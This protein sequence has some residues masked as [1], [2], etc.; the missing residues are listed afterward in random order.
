MSK[1]NDFLRGVKVIDVSQFLPGPFA[2]LLMADMGATVLK[3]EPPGGDEAK[4]Y[5]PAFPDGTPAFHEATN[6]GKFVIEIDL[7]SATGKERFL[8]LAADADVLVE[9]FRPGVMEKLGLGYA[10]IKKRNPEI[11]YCSISGF[12]QGQ[13]MRAGHDGN[14]LA[15]AGVLDRNGTTEPVL[16]DP[17]PAD[18]AGSFFALTAILGA[19][20]GRDRGIGGCHIDIGLA[21]SIHPLQ[22]REL[23]A[24]AATGLN[25]TRETTLSSGGF[26][27]NSVYRTSAGYHIV[28]SGME[29]KFWN[30]FCERAGRPDW[31]ERISDPMPQVDLKREVADFILRLSEEEVQSLIDDPDVCVARVLTL[32]EAVE[33]AINGTRN[34]IVRVEDRIQPLFPALLNGQTPGL[35]VPP[36][37][38]DDLSSLEWSGLVSHS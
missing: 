18:F 20:H 23:A 26:A 32:S 3:V 5:G 21:D 17:P 11:I 34:L 28:F 9:G 30:R 15:E 31:R 24:F 1:L 38:L 29:P 2:G 22:I 36:R 33:R 10:G 8:H 14:Y 25:P 19:L 4:R 6:S 16:F 12:G 13:S 37:I 35:R 7:K 27:R